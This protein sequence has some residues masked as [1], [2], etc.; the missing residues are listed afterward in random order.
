MVSIL[1][2]FP[3]GVTMFIALAQGFCRERA[4]LWR[5]KRKKFIFIF[6]RE[7]FFFSKEKNIYNIQSGQ[8]PVASIAILPYKK[9]GAIKR[10]KKI[11]NIRSALRAINNQSCVFPLF[12]MFGKEN[13]IVE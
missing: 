10:N 1:N 4:G 8:C 12:E 3:E 6:L 5:K 2:S 11:K 13:N 9:R 7:F